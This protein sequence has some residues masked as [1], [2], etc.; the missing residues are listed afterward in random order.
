MAPMPSQW[1]QRVPSPQLLNGVEEVE[2]RVH[3]VPHTPL[4][5]EGP[6]SCL[7]R[8]SLGAVSH[9]PQT[10]EGR[11]SHEPRYRACLTGCAL[12]L[13]GRSRGVCRVRAGV[14]LSVASS[15]WKRSRRWMLWRRCTFTQPS[16]IL[17]D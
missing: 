16:G 3:R 1:L 6:L 11:V 13:A 12:S 17:V 5:L 15:H 9:K 7:T 8:A 14:T 4:V 2:V 10:R